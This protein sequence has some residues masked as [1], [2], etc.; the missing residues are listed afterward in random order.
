MS[1]NNTKSDHSSNNS[2]ANLYAFLKANFPEGSQMISEEENRV[3]LFQETTVCSKISVCSIILN[4]SVALNKHE[5]K[6]DNNGLYT[7]YSLNGNFREA[8][9]LGIAVAKEK[10]FNFQWALSC[11][12][13]LHRLVLSQK[14]VGL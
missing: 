1:E 7:L 10:H 3:N 5:L 12:P 4:N 8:R 11:D 13:R 14:W 9:R 6:T 2:Y